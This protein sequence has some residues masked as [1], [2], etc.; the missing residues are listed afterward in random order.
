[1]A[2]QCL[3]QAC[4]RTP[5]DCA[6]YCGHVETIQLLLEQGANPAHLDKV[7]HACA[8]LVQKVAHSLHVQ[9]A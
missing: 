4:K 3:A 1:M 9:E 7:S 6:A 8:W 5:L 2:F